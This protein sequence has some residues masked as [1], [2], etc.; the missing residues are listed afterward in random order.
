MIHL[1]ILGPLTLTENG[2]TRL[3]GVTS[4]SSYRSKEEMCLNSRSL[5]GRV[6]EPTILKWIKSNI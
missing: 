4:S 2:I 5:Y 1:F 3:Y 6:S